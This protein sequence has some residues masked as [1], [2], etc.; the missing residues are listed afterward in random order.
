MS[1][2]AP[3]TLGELT[4][5][6]LVKDEAM[7]PND[8]HRGPLCLQSDLNHL[9]HC[10]SIHRLKHLYLSGIRM[11]HLRPKPLWV[12]LVKAADT[13]DPG[14][15][16]LWDQGLSAH[17]IHCYGKGISTSTL[18]NLLHHTARISQLSME[19]PCFSGKQV[20]SVWGKVCPSLMSW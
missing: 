6:S 17:H 19:L 3:P 8:P 12:L 18:E 10:P 20:Y 5:Q 16:T 7:R 2:R 13:P 11:T 9:S 14:L 15:Q 1:I 4:R